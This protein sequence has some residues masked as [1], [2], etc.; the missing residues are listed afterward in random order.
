MV[1]YRKQK[2]GMINK[3]TTFDLILKIFFYYGFNI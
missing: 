1:E 3:E 2:Y